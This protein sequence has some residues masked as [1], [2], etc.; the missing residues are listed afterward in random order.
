MAIPLLKALNEL[1]PDLK[2]SYML[3]DAGYDYTPI[4]QQA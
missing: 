2:P 4:Y 1:H 3:A